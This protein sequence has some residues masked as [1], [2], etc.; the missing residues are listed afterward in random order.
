MPLKTLLL[1]KFADDGFCSNGLMIVVHRLELLLLLLLPLM[2]DADSRCDLKM[3][4]HRGAYWRVELHWLGVLDLRDPSLTLI[5]PDLLKVN[6]PL[7]SR[8]QRLWKKI[9]RDVWI[10]HSTTS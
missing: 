4:H 6:G 3:I 9:R 8:I 5:Q 1:I 7:C 10:L 2:K